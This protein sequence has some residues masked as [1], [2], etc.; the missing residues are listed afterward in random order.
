MSSD[1]WFRRTTWTDA[2]R[3]D[4]RARLQCARKSNRP[5][6]LRIQAHHLADAGNP[7]A[8]LEL[9]DQFADIDDGGVDLASAQLQR[10]ESLFATGDT[11]GAISAFRDTLTAERNRPNVQTAAWLLFP[12]FIVEL[13]LTG[14]YPE[15]AS[16]LSEFAPIRRLSFPIDKYRY[17]AI[18]A[19]LAAHAGHT[20]TATEYAANALIASSA[21]HS[22]FRYHPEIGLVQNVATSIRERVTAIAAT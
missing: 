5:Q 12:W 14:L 2:D 1:D 13:Q 22:G 3:L 16:V 6:Y 8:A 7:V 10:G 18:N 19:L 21:T 20:L 4:F 11:A 9:L 15:A 17:N